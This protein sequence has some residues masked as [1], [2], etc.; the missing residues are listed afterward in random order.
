MRNLHS[1]TEDELF[2]L[3]SLNSINIANELIL[4]NDKD[5]INFI[6]SERYWSNREFLGKKY[7]IFKT[8]GVDNMET[9]Y[10]PII[11]ETRNYEDFNCG[12]DVYNIETG[13]VI[14]MM[15]EYLEPIQTI[16]WFLKNGFT[17]GRLQLKSDN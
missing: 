13:F 12:I 10:I 11:Y 7:V 9:L 1:I 3:L 14:G 16:E 15:G 6:E 4:Q 2:E 17:V 5:S 8:Y